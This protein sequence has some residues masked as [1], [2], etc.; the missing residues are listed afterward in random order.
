M[1]KSAQ[2]EHATSAKSA[3]GAFNVRSVA[4]L[5]LAVMVV[6]LAG[7]VLTRGRGNAFPAGISEADIAQAQR[8][9]RETFGIDPDYAD[10]LAMLGKLL[11]KDDR[12][13]IAVSCY[14]A[15]PVTHPRFGLAARLQAG[16][17]LGRL[18]RAAAAE[19]AFREYL[20]LTAGRRD[21]VAEGRV[22]AREWLTYLLSVELRFEERQA[23][24][25]ASHIEGLADLNDSKQYFFPYL[26]L[27][28]TTR[29]ASQLREFLWVD[30]DN[31]QLQIA[32]GRYLTGEGRP[33]LAERLLRDL[34]TRLPG[35]LRCIAAL[36]E[37]LYEQD[38]WSE[39]SPVIA[40]VPDFD[41]SEPWL[42]TEMRGQFALQEQRWDDARREFQRLLAVVPTHSACQMGLVTA[43][44]H[45]DDET[46]LHEA[47]E[48]SLA[49]ARIRV[50][51]PRVKI[52][53]PAEILKFAEQCDQI[54]LTDAAAVFRSYARQNAE[55]PGRAE[56]Q[57]DD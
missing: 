49:L 55:S 40:D 50:N 33:D 34:C 52:G 45:L 30:P 42:L 14:E 47:E 44:R 41:S 36:L 16:V 51:L 7:V 54:G 10:T 6:G 25:A 39:F 27:Y 38:D 29:G 11:D 5:L 8:Q 28:R 31:P 17:S 9:F 19:N 37:C 56:L 12:L 57:A 20:D 23:I 13:Q 24:H 26:L 35:N 53:H 22:T 21:G 32:L 15:I 48:K 3:T 18:N 43:L 4:L 1:T 2:Q 46:A